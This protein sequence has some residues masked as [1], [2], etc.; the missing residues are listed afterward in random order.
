MILDTKYIEERLRAYILPRK[1]TTADEESA[2]YRAVDAQIAYETANGAGQLGLGALPGNVASISNDGVSMTFQGSAAAQ[3]G[4]SRDTLSPAA[5]AILRNAGLIA[6][7]LPTA[8]K[9]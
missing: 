1:P 8:R 5:W 7:T 9:P 6:Y 3:D 2:F 4:Y